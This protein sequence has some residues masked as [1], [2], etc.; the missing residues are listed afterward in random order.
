MNLRD[1]QVEILDSVRNATTN[2]LVQLDTG[3]GKTPIEAAL[4]SQAEH[5][6]IVAH[7]VTLISQISEKLAA[8]GLEHDTVSTDYTRRRCASMHRRYGGNFIVRGHNKRLV[9]SIDSLHAQE[10][11]GALS[12]IDF[13]APWLI[14][15]DE[16]HH[17]LPDNKWGRLR[18]LFPNARFVG[19][20][21]TPARMDGESLHVLKGGLFERLVQAQ[22]LGDDSVQKLISRGYL[23]DF[24]VYAASRV[25]AQSPHDARGLDYRSGEV[26]LHADPVREYKR[27]ADGT[28]AILMAPAIRN[29]ENFATQFRTAGVAAACIH[30]KMPSS[31][32]SRALDAFRAGVVRVICNVDMIGEGFDL[33]AVETLIIATE[34]ASFPRYRQ[35]VGRVLRPSPGKRRAIII[36]LTGQ[37]A[38][39]GMPD[40]PVHWDLL[41]PP[42]GPV[43]PYHAPCN[44]CG[45]YYKAR[46][47]KCP[48]CGAP[49]V[50]HDGKGIGNY[51]F[52]IRILDFHLL[53]H[54]REERIRKL[55]DE[56][57][58][59][60]IV[61]RPQIAACGAFRRVAN[62]LLDWYVEQLV[63]AGT[64]FRE[65]NTFLCSTD[66]ASLSWWVDRFSASDLRMSSS[67]ARRKA[68]E[69]HRAWLHSRATN[70]SAA[71]QAL[72]ARKPI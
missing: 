43:A 46:L 13:L 49:N 7:R 50:I 68:L 64:P 62:Q 58:D 42:C 47:N 22:S 60:E 33:P 20:T 8:F 61:H 37:V 23:S 29:A 39:H 31:I 18:D 9:V 3:A 16:A 66:A 10:R 32:V 38:A 28:Q 56:R 5:C 72:T 70:S 34:T 54:L 11:R 41:N 57:L 25:I 45:S 65:I 26:R 59:R 55:A 30:S 4:A 53:E 24:V 67:A 2:D 1:Y 44:E 27:R 35:W 48:E 12:K 15:I 17:V 69:I 63:S 40:Q 6:M 14:I 36:D 52:D 71:T 51:E 21:A 19:F